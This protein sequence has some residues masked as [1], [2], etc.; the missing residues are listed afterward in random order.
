[1]PNHH[2]HYNA[3]APYI[4]KDGSAIRELMHPAVQGNALQSL[5]EATVPPG[6]V[7]ALHLHRAS[8]EIYYFIQGEGMMHLGDEQFPERSG[9][10]VAIPPGIAHNVRNTGN[11][12]LKILC[13][14]SPAYRHDDTILLGA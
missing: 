6:A 4:T 12:P 14:C 13:A 10:S 11:V 3:V 9:D 8:E 1:M 5:A 2:S 7:T